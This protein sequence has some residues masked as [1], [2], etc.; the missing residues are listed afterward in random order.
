MNPFVTALRQES[1]K[2][3]IA[4]SN[5]FVLVEWCSI[6]LIGLAGSPLWDK[7]GLDI[8]HAD[9]AALEKCL[10]PSSKSS[11]SKSA[12]VVTR[13][14][15][16][17]AFWKGGLREKVIKDVVE[18]LIAKG[19]Q[20][21]ARNA[22]LLGVVAGV[23]SRHNQA[24]DVLVAK[25]S[26]Y[27]TFFT[28]EIIGSRTPIPEHMTNGLGD[29]FSDFV[30]SEDLEKNVIPP[31]E[32][33]LLRAPEV[34]LAI[35]TP[36]IGSLSKDIDLSKTLSSHLLKPL[37]S[38]V[39]STN[40]AI[41]AGVLAVF[42]S[43][44]ARSR[45]TKLLEQVS[46][47]ILN[48]LKSGKLASADHRIL[49]SEMLESVPLTNPVSIKVV[50]GLPPITAKEGNEGALNAEIRLL[51]Q[52]VTQLLKDGSELP[53]PVVDAFVKG[54]ADKKI[55]SRRLWL[56]QAGEI[57]V[58]FAGS[59]ELPKNV[60][61]FADS[62]AT[63]MSETWAEIIKN[64]AAAAQNGLIAGAYVFAVLSY[65]I[66]ANV[67][68][69]GVKA[70]LKKAAV[71]KESLVAEPKPSYLLNHRIYGRLSNEDDSRWFLRAL[72][73]VSD[74]I[75]KTSSDVQVAWS[76][77]LIYLVSSTS[78]SPKIRKEGCET[79]SKLYARNPHITSGIV[80]NGLWQWIES[81]DLADKDSVAAHAKFDTNHLQAVLRSLCLTADEVTRFGV[82]ARDQDVIE[83]QMCSLLVISRDDL[84]PRSSW[85]E[86]C[87]R[88]GVDPGTL[89]KKYE[90]DLIQ[91][92]VE[93]T[94]ASQKVSN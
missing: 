61:Q 67:D 29:F 7:F 26:D 23:C 66:L 21:S 51:S 16:R 48:P 71:P 64:P 43:A 52:S 54:L 87:L 4:P 11:V 59:P 60:T 58:S 73:A 8:I 5:A 79:I 86:L 34:V 69:T 37:L 25:K 19:S 88:V 40:P 35:V 80:I 65:Q 6:F 62:I 89:A 55:P 42:K 47:E 38:N 20:P 28:R 49:H 36:L 56:L 90:E 12:L 85:I 75:V 93:K 68:T 76:Q 44:S 24:K 41:R 17:A 83:K 15:L 74:N 31:I 50:T 22:V 84:I 2:P 77:A 63:P 91:Q 45:D 72:A 57:L 94:S 81:S 70:V 1:Q 92:V 18:A 30:T 82:E 39:K 78:I 9:A 13:R 14:G 53:K 46:D 3:G 33:G 32:K 10:Q 27:F